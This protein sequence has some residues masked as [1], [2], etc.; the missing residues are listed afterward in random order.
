MFFI[1]NTEI[2]LC[3]VLCRIETLLDAWEDNYEVKIRS[4]P[5]MIYV[6]WC[7]CTKS[8]LTQIEREFC[9]NVDDSKKVLRG[10]IWPFF[11]GSFWRWAWHNREPVLHH[12]L[13]GSLCLSLKMISFYICFLCLIVSSSYKASKIVCIQPKLITSFKRATF[14]KS[15][16]S[17]SNQLRKLWLYL[18]V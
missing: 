15:N 1:Y 5:D 12:L 11:F 4:L 13:Q 18:S 8:Y 7:C 3:A 9:H 6:Y 14:Q 10:W 2:L 17:V 16:K